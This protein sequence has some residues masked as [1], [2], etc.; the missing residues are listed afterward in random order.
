MCEEKDG[1]LIKAW[2]KWK[3]DRKTDM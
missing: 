3:Y 1:Q 2:E